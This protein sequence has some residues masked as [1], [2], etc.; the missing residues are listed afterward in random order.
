[1]TSWLR[2]MRSF[3]VLLPLSLL[4]FFLTLVISALLNKLPVE[5]IETLLSCEKNGPTVSHLKK[6]LSCLKS[7]RLKSVFFEN[8]LSRNLLTILAKKKFSRRRH[9]L[10]KKLFCSTFKD[11]RSLVSRC[12]SVI[13][14]RRLDHVDLGSKTVRHLARPFSPSF[15][16][17]GSFISRAITIGP[18]KEV[19]TSK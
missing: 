6:N 16:F 2:G 13:D 4:H 7:N 15:L 10:K 19:L 11:R 3:T 14:Q 1:M 5:S 18:L 17:V 12:S 9:R 8:W